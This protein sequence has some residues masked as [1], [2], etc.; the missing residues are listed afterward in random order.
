MLHNVNGRNEIELAVRR[1]EQ[2][3]RVPTRYVC[4]SQAP[5]NLGLPKVAV[6]TRRLPVTGALKK[7]EE[8]A[9]ATAQIKYSRLPFRGEMAS[10]PLAKHAFIA[11]QQIGRRR[12]ESMVR[13]KLAVPAESR[14]AQVA[15]EETTT[16]PPA[17]AIAAQTANH[18]ALAGM[19][20]FKFCG[21]PRLCGRL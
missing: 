5:G 14:Y 8:L 3:T 19:C 11:A 2:L 10:E 4:D 12:R 1:P 13:P 18:A 6:Y 7:T 21:M 17:V 9:I 15:H 20:R 16:L